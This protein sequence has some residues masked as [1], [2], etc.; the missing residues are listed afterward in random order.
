MYSA[1]PPFHALFAYYDGTQRFFIWSSLPVSA[2]EESSQY[3][4]VFD[5]AIIDTILTSAVVFGGSAAHTLDAIC[6]RVEIK[7]C[8]GRGRCTFGGMKAQSD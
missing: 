1:P 2:P 4:R 3:D 7:I 8:E 5:K 6:G